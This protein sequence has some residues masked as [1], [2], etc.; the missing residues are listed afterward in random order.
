MIF[1]RLRPGLIALAL[2]ILLP[3]CSSID[4]SHRSENSR[5]LPGPPAKLQTPVY[6]LNDDAGRRVDLVGAVHIGDKSYYQALNRRFR[7]YD[8]VLVEGV[9]DPG[10][11]KKGSPGSEG[12]RSLV[13]QDFRMSFQ[14]EE[15]D[16]GRPNIVHADF[17]NAAYAAARKQHGLGDRTS[18]PG[19]EAVVM[20]RLRIIDWGVS[21]VQRASAVS[22]HASAQKFPGGKADYQVDVVERERIALDVLERQ[23][24]AGKRNLC[25]FYG[26]GHLPTL[27]DKLLDRGW[28]L[29][30]VEWLDAWVIPHEL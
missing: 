14:G 29:E 19:N 25:I 1:Q 9:G 12:F 23:L 3:A 17:T 6:I 10:K 5:Y 18:E 28:K 20:M 11:R 2:A 7:D 30:G 27:R 21:K 24:A 15:I 4:R 26:S 22:V 16:Y 8:A 13:H